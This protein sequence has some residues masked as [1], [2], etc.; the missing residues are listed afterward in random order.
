[1][2]DPVSKPLESFD[3]IPLKAR[4]S[5][6]QCA[7]NHRE[8]RRR[9]AKAPWSLGHLI[10]CL[11]CRDA[12]N[13][14]YIGEAVPQDFRRRTAD[15][16]TTGVPFTPRPPA[17]DSDVYCKGMAQ[18]PE[19]SSSKPNYSKNSTSL[20]VAETATLE[21]KEETAVAQTVINGPQGFCAKHPTEMQIV[22]NKD[23]PRKGQL[24][25]MCKKCMEERRG[26]RSAG[27]RKERGKKGNHVLILN[28]EA[29]SDEELWADLHQ[30]ASDEFR[31]PEMQAL[32][33]IRVMLRGQETEA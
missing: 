18:K 20:V 28:F 4:I 8:A 10:H 22:I 19:K 29:C 16:L 1:M 27:P 12:R 15:K 5:P 6:R 17:P 31:T 3:C 21:I 14:S 24:T 11:E 25:G 30:E 23:G 13:E 33:L 9:N 32:H 2:A 26:K 7:I